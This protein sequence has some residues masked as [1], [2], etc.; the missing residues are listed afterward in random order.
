MRPLWDHCGGHCEE[1]TVTGGL[2]RKLGQEAVDSLEPRFA[3]K[4]QIGQIK[5]EAARGRSSRSRSSPGLPARSRSTPRPPRPGTPCLKCNSKDPTVKR[6]LEAPIH[7]VSAETDATLMDAKNAEEKWKK[8][9][10]DASRLADELRG[11]QDHTTTQLAQKRSAEA[12]LTESESG[13]ASGEAAAMKGGKSV[14]AR[15]EQR[16]RELEAELGSIQGRAGET[17]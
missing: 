6:D 3:S 9:M 10:M 5:Q 16:V 1:T 8:A 13:L 12:S 15:L 4:R 2:H 7:T 11:Q 17:M 14:L